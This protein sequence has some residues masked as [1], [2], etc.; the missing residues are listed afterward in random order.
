MYEIASLTAQTT[1]F[2]YCFVF[3]WRERTSRYRAGVPVVLFFMLGILFLLTHQIIRLVD[4]GMTDPSVLDNFGAF[5]E[6]L[7][8]V[9]MFIGIHVYHSRQVALERTRASATQRLRAVLP[10]SKS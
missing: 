10:E 7:G 6:T 4:S 3:A 9:W 8:F 2:T 1:L 5:I